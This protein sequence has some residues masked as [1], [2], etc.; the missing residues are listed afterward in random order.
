MRSG[1]QFVLQ[2]H[3]DL[4]PDLA[5]ERGPSQEGVGW[6][7][8]EVK[9]T[10]IGKYIHATR[11]AQ[12]KFKERVLIDPFCGPGRIQVKGESFTRD[13]G[14]I[15]AWNQSVLSNCRFTKVLIGDI[16]PDRA[17]ACEA[18]LSALGAPVLKFDGPA[19]ETVDQMARAVPFGALCLAY[20]DPYNLEF[21]S[22][23]LI[24][25]LAKLPNVDFAVHFSLMDLSRN[26]DM[27]LDPNRDRFRHASPGWRDRAPATTLPKAKLATWFFE[28]WCRQIADLGFSIQRE[29][30]LVA[31]GNGRVLYRLVFFSRHAL[32]DRIWGDIAKSPNLQFDF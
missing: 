8:P 18:R 17:L 24:K 29:M 23:S 9:H 2:V 3:P 7:V 6:W 14:A 21:L 11:K 16:L 25:R 31:D 10:L 15:A 28:D 32:P 20:I 22:M 4:R 26:V 13:G 1:S 5:V 30:P 27:E 19:E 12:L